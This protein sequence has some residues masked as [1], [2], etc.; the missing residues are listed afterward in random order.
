[1]KEPTAKILFKIGE[2]RIE[3]TL[4]EAQKLCVR[5]LLIGD[6]SMWCEYIITPELSVRLV[7]D[8]P[9]P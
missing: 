4:E 2:K 7:G 1:M 3:V 9:G 8:A 5:L 6:R